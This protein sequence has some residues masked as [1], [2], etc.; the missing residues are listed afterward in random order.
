MKRYLAAA[1]ACL[2]PSLAVAQ[3]LPDAIRSRGFVR[4]AVETTY[5]PMSY[6]DPATNERRGVNADLLA[7][8]SKELGIEFRYEE[9]AF[10]QLV[11][12]VTTER[13][14][15]SGTSMTETPA[16]R[17]RLTFVDYA[18]TGA[19]IFTTVT[20]QKGATKPE[21]FCGRSIATPRTTNYFKQVQD[22]SEA[23]CVAKGKPA[24]RVIGT[25]GAAAARTDLQQGRA[26]GVVLGAEYVV[27]LS[28]QNPGTFVTIGEPLTRGLFGF[29]FDQKQTAL[30]DAIAAG[31]SR[32]IA[33]G[34]Y[35]EV[36]RK[37]GLEHQAITEV[38][39]DKG[40]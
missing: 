39:I 32:L 22:W 18:S 29:A 23:N 16:R 35:L 9:M 6:K 25:E 11:P 3:V 8:L 26:D 7:A 19:Q 13:V 37:H 17:E 36:L 31:L 10:A 33:N 4:V 30:R 34:T 38:S 27:Y 1:F 21:D 2:I 20:L 15:F 28:Q 5:P 24:I 40:E 14:D 12:A